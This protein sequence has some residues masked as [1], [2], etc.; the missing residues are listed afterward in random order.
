MN[1]HQNIPLLSKKEMTDYANFANLCELIDMGI[2]HQQ[3]VR[4]SEETE[5]AITCL[6]G[7]DYTTLQNAAKEIRPKSGLDFPAANLKET[8]RRKGG[9]GL[10]LDEAI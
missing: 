9:I 8:Q 3:L 2:M 6:P 7:E 5:P 1:L 10:H 4:S